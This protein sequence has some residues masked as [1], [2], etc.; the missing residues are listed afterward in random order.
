M[1]TGA[2][3]V[4]QRLA[5]FTR[6]ELL[7]AP[8]NL[9]RHP[10]M[11]GGAFKLM[12]DALENRR[13]FAAYVRN[14]AK[15]GYSYWVFAT[16]TPLG[17][18]FLSVR[19]AP[20]DGQLW[21]TASDIY[22]S[23]LPAEAAAR[24]A[25][26]NRAE[27][28]AV[29]RDRLA[30]T[31]ERAGF[32]S[33]DDF[34]FEALP[35]ETV[36]RSAQLGRRAAAHHG[37]GGAVG[38]IL[39]EASALGERL[40]EVLGRLDSLRQLAESLGAGAGQ[41]S[42]TLRVLAEV[43][44]LASAASE[45]V[46]RRAPVLASTARAMCSVGADVDRVIRPL[47]DRLG[48]VRDK[49]NRLRFGIALGCLHNDMVVNFAVEVLDGLA[50]PDGLRQVPL[51]CRALSD[52]VGTLTLDLDSATTTLAEVSAEVEACSAQFGQFQKLLT[53][54]RLQVPRYGLSR[55]LEPL[56][57]PIDEQLARGHGELAALRGL[58]AQCSGAAEPVDGAP[59]QDSIDR[60]SRLADGLLAAPADAAAASG[61]GLPVPVAAATA[62]ALADP[63]GIAGPAAFAAPAGVAALA[64]ADQ[65]AG[66]TW[67]Y[68]PVLALAR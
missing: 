23:V 34:M 33:Y 65:A 20:C 67:G 57:G 30:E 17:G 43:T 49:V 7:G 63:P 44:A 61:A 45:R 47:A 21:Q 5:A 10:E 28:A 26:L 12:W 53:A 51:L 62:A 15:D 35:A 1:I 38:E 18:G 11:P 41:L 66:R 22:R 64:E 42:A 39:R 3:S 58:A 8:H 54:W 31:L 36:A 40:G 25:G 9:I 4:F 50:P 24:R 48:R 29:G 56:V 68:Q 52:D 59:L 19:S 14:L 2:N 16:V 46:E 32:D 37:S 13:P 6:A 27:S 55:R 60:I